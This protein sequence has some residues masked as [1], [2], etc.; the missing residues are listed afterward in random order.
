MGY[1][2]RRCKVNCTQPAI[3]K[4][5]E[6]CGLQAHFVNNKDGQRACKYHFMQIYI[7]YKYGKDS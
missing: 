7:Q 5:Q 1:P 6:T 3:D 4:P 2:Q